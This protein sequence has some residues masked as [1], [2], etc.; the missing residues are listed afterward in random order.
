VDAVIWTNLGWTIPDVAKFYAKDAL[1]WLRNLRQ[2]GKS[3]TAE[4]YL[5][6][7]PSQMDTCVRRQA[8]DEFGWNDIP[9]A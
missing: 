5:R 1:D 9:A 3:D 8:K 7:A 6:K 4:E 2:Q